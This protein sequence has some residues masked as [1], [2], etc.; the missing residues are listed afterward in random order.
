M[1]PFLLLVIQELK[2]KQGVMQIIDIEIDE[3]D[4]RTVTFVLGDLELS[5]WYGDDWDHSKDE[6]VYEQ[7]ISR[8]KTITFPNELEVLS[9]E[10]SYSINWY[11]ADMKRREVPCLIIIP[12]E[13]LEGCCSGYGDAFHAALA[14]PPDAQIKKFYFGD[15]MDPDLD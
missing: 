8:R 7:F 6:P 10:E 5:D 1:S 14:L 15:R 2:R 12:G 11:K 4:E 3:K 13:T 9:H